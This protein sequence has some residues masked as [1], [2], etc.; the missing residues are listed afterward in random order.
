MEN[1]SKACELGVHLESFSSG[2]S[3]KRT[4]LDLENL[5]NETS[6]EP[7]RPN[8]TNNVDH[9]VKQMR[10]IKKV[11]KYLGEIVGTEGKGLI[12]YVELAKRI[13]F[14]LNLLKLWQVSPDAAKEFRR[15]SMRT[16]KKKRKHTKSNIFS[17][18]FENSRTE[19][20]YSNPTLSLE[21]KAFGLPVIAKVEADVKLVNY[22]YRNLSHKRIRAQK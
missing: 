3:N 15:L 19:K 8:D 16:N 20:T 22:H 13:Y 14:Q 12:N 10:N 4:R 11:L 6:F 2:P 18:S 5:L 7:N 17:N 21:Q 9:P 1:E